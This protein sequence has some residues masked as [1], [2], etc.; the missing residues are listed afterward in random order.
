MQSCAKHSLYPHLGSGGVGGGG[1]HI[2]GNDSPMSHGLWKNVKSLGTRETGLVLFRIQIWKGFMGETWL[3]VW[4]TDKSLPDGH[5]ETFQEQTPG[6][7]KLWHQR[8]AFLGGIKPWLVECA[9]VRVG[10]KGGRTDRGPCT[11]CPDR[12][13][14]PRGSG[15]LGR[16]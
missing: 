4:R 7:C 10:G 15:G 2:P 8:L 13:P 14:Y 9:A 1:R 16:V 11:P 5:V 6:M 12:G 3:W